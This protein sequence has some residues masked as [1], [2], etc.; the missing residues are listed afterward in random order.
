[1]PIGRSSKKSLRKSVKNKKVNSTFKNKL[2]E[3]VKKFLAKPEKKSF[4]EVQAILDKAQRKH[5]FQKNK[6]VRLKARYAKQV[7]KA[8]E[9][10]VVKK[11][12]AKKVLKKK[13]SKK[14]K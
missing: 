10:V 13:I 3:V 6:V 14:M 1:M 9:K 4:G 2:K 12:S 8:V 7:G 5:L 11:K